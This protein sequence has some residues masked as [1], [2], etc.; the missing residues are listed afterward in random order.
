MEMNMSM[1]TGQK[2]CRMLGVFMVIMME[3]GLGV[4]YA[5]EWPTYDAAGGTLPQEQGW[6]FYDAN[7]PTSPM[8]VDGLLHQGLTTAA[9]IQGWTDDSRIFCF[10]SQDRFYLS[11]RLKVIESD[12]AV[13]NNQWDCGYKV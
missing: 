9:G 5:G 13:V 4:C 11:F 6:T 2:I 10:G 3:T 8:V 12:Y 7:E 1:D